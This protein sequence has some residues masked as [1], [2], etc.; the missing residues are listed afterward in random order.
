MTTK[1]RHALTQESGMPPSGMP[2]GGVQPIHLS[3]PH[4]YPITLDLFNDFAGVDSSYYQEVK[5]AT[6]RL[7]QLSVNE[8]IIL[9]NALFVQLIG[10]DV[11]LTDLNSDSV[12]SYNGENLL[13]EQG[14]N[15][16]SHIK[17]R[18]IGNPVS[19]IWTKS[20]PFINDSATNP[21]R[22]CAMQFHPST[23][24]FYTQPLR[25][26]TQ[27]SFGNKEIESIPFK[28]FGPHIKNSAYFLKLNRMLSANSSFQLT[29]PPHS[30]L[31]LY[32]HINKDCVACLPEECC[33][34]DTE[35][36]QALPCSKPILPFWLILLFIT[37]SALLL[38]VRFKTP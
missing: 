38:F 9:E 23:T 30:S 12:I 32:L 36:E 13:L 3:N 28:D 14:F 18:A 1:D 19:L 17:I 26:I 4:P 8:E 15:L 16:A 7:K 22:V 2:L 6:P 21:R 5:T 37:A 10:G 24:D 33:L 20:S 11:E 29:L 34:E 31:S 25:W 27:N 35:L